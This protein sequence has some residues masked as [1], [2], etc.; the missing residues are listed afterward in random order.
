MAL[1]YVWCYSLEQSTVILRHA[2]Q[3]FNCSN[4]FRDTEF[5]CTGFSNKSSFRSL[6]FNGMFQKYFSIKHNVELRLCTP[7]RPGEGVDVL[8]HSFLM[9][10]IQGNGQFHAPATLPAEKQLWLTV[11]KSN[12]ISHWYSLGL[13]SSELLSSTLVFVYRRFVTAYRPNSRVMQSSGLFDPLRWSEEANP[14]P[15]RG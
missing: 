11:G 1:C 13:P 3:V 6:I 15:Y 12:R 9:P 7:W 8:L 4:E 2:R 5:C 14:H 10:E